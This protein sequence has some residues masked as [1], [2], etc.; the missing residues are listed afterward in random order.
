MQGI[1]KKFLQEIK[2]RSWGPSTSF[3][4]ERM[5]VAKQRKTNPPCT[6]CCHCS[7]LFLSGTV[8]VKLCFHW[9]LDQ[10]THKKVNTDKQGHK[11][12]LNWHAPSPLSWSRGV[13][14]GKA[15]E[16]KHQLKCINVYNVHIG[17]Y[18]GIC[19]AGAGFDIAVE[20]NSGRHCTSFYNCRLS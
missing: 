13:C 18:F 7:S 10:Y 20:S 15:R 8:F 4:T 6:C 5:V 1:L 17:W 11:Y 12:V 14:D 19:I 9:D 16:A 3:K 2:V